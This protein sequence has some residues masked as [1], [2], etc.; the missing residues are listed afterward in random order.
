MKNSSPSQG[1]IV[2][3]PSR[4]IP[5][6][7]P[8]SAPLLARSSSTASL[9]MGW[10]AVM[11]RISASGSPVEAKALPSYP[12]SSSTRPTCPEKILKA[13]RSDRGAGCFTHFC[14][15]GLVGIET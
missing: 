8:H 12:V 14:A 3:F 11:S 4:S 6:T 5:S 2:I 7:R 1:A 13:F 9:L 15:G 10:T